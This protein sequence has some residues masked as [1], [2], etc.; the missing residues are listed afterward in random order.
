MLIQ[1]S[2]LH[3]FLG[4]HLKDVQ[5]MKFFIKEDCLYIGEHLASLVPAQ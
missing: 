3:E 2:H 4:G 1:V 5:N